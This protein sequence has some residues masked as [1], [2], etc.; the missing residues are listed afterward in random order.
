MNRLA[1]LSFRIILKPRL[2]ANSL[3]P[4]NRSFQQMPIKCVPILNDKLNGF[5]Q[6][7]IQKRY[8]KKFTKKSN[9]R[10][11]KDDED[12]EDE[13]DE[14]EDSD[15]DDE[16]LIGNESEDTKV[17]NTTVP[18]L[19]LDV[20]GKISFGMTR[21]KMEQEFFSG[22]IRVNGERVAKKSYEV[23]MDD[24]IDYIKGFNIEN[25]EMLD[26]N[27]A[28]ILKVDDKA[29]SSGRIRLSI[30]KTNKL[31]IANYER[32]PYESTI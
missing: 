14:N 23:K 32:D 1:N 19:R 18:S 22:L 5:E 25:R 10:A 9:K 28:K 3:I 13:D 20:I 24:E 11:A 12:D 27:R 7:T 8:K 17:I 16:E 2:V 29:A 6:F 31:V 4:I 30:R 26:I 15:D 21:S